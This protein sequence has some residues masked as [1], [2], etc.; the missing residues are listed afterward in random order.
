MNE[1]LLLAAMSA[2]RVSPAID[3]NDHLRVAAEAAA[4][5]EARR[6][7]EEDFIRMSRE[8][9]TIVL[10]AR[11]KQKYDEL[12]VRGAIHL[13]FPDMTTATLARAIPRRTTRVLIYCNN[14]FKNAEIP[15]P[16][17]SAASALNIST[18]IALYDYGYRNV[19]ELGP[20]VDIETSR[21]PFEGTEAAAIA[22]KSGP[23]R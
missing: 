6:V 8:P 7:T 1:F 16:T 20:L 15:F 22:R 13:S 10:D 19:Y 9:A 23:A 5:R 11:S 21:L 4:H 17:K 3:M 18:F 12:H 2:V 14:N